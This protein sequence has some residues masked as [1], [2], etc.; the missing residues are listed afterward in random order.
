MT[1]TP[2]M[3]SILAGEKKTRQFS[4]TAKK[5]AATRPAKLFLK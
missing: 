3:L 5:V 1:S 4:A 2:Q